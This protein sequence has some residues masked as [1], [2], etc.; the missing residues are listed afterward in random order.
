M[1][2]LYGH[3]GLFPSA[4]FHFYPARMFSCITCIIKQS[5]RVKTANWECTRDCLKVAWIS[6]GGSH[7]HG[8]TNKGRKFFDVEL[9][10]GC[11]VP[12]QGD[13]ET[14]KM[15]QHFDK[16]SIALVS[17]L[18]VYPLC[19]MHLFWIYSCEKSI[20]IYKYQRRF[21]SHTHT[22]THT[23]KEGK[24]EARRKVGKGRKVERREER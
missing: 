2:G 18:K 15:G 19:N 11:D 17:V 3:F 1:R 12:G 16:S 24:E 13:V 6:R 9:E 14:Q 22:H 7:H 5:F 4:M 10:V 20:D 8:V 21:I 23:Q